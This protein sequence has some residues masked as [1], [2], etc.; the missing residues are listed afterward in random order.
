[1]NTKN[2]FGI[3]LFFLCTINLV[4]CEKEEDDFLSKE[5]ENSTVISGTVHTKD[6]QPLSGVNIKMDYY[7]SAWLQ[8][9]LVRHKAKAKT[10]KNGNYKLELYVRDDELQ[11]NENI[12]KYFDLVVD[13]KNLDSKQYILPGEMISNVISVDP[14]VVKPA[15][16]TAPIIS[17]NISLE[18]NKTY[19]QDFYIPQK[20][21]VQITLKGFTPNQNNAHFEVS[22]FFPWG[23]ESDEEKMID[24]K[25]NIGHSAMDMYVASSKEQTFEVPF[26]LNENNIVRLTKRKNG[27]L[28]SED[29]KIFVT[30]DS[31]KSLTYEY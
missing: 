8:Y 26:A 13:M 15:T 2:L 25:Y 4:S 5:T 14:L 1:M 20:R 21:S 9:S 27:I 10:D 23:G 24:T 19:T 18:R 3:I 28:T 29:Y 7:E 30:K 11:R 6:G 31:P 12:R 22:S 16:D 17:Y